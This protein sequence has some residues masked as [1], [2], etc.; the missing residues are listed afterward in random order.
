M[1]F[2]FYNLNSPKYLSFWPNCISFLLGYGLKILNMYRAS[3]LVV[4]SLEEESAVAYTNTMGLLELKALCQCMN[5][6]TRTIKSLQRVKKIQKK[7]LPYSCFQVGT[8]PPSVVSSIPLSSHLY[9]PDQFQIC[10]ASAYLSIHGYRYLLYY[11]FVASVECLYI[12]CWTVLLLLLLA[13]LISSLLL[14]SS[15][16]SPPPS[17]QQRG[18]RS[19]ARSTAD[20]REETLPSSFAADAGSFCSYVG[21]R[22]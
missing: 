5:Y 21:V 6:L 4:P 14:A 8:L 19:G 10:L 1:N 7:N 15:L 16:C 20:K 3:P 18:V 22:A 17:L 11:I 2:T 12:F 13:P 9:F